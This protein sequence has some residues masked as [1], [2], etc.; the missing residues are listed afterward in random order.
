[1]QLL[2]T[3]IVDTGATKRTSTET[4]H[5]RCALTLPTVP[6]SSLTYEQQLAIATVQGLCANPTCYNVYEDLPVMA[7]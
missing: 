7:V 1:M 4:H 6:P 2:G 3:V 5:A